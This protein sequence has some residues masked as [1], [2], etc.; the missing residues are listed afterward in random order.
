MF[1]SSLVKQGLIFSRIHFVYQLLHELL[2]DLRVRT[3]SNQEISGK[4]RISMEAD[5]SFQSFIQK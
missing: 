5:R 1:D 3:L 4:S 2:K